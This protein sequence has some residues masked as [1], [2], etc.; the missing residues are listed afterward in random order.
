MRIL[1]RLGDE[2]GQA[3]PLVVAAAVVLIGFAGLAID[4]GRVWVAKQQL[5]QAVDASAVAAGQYL[6]SSQ[7]AYTN[8]ITYAAYGSGSKNPATGV[9]VTAAQPVV[10]FK[11][12]PN[13]TGYVAGTCPTDTSGKNCN[14]TGSATPTSSTCNAVNVTETETV[15]AGFLSL[16]IPHFTIKASS[17]AGNR[18]SSAVPDPMNVEVILDTTESM[19][20]DCAATLT[21][22]DGSTVTTTFTFKGKTTNGSKTITSITSLSGTLS[23][24]ESITASGIPSGTVVV[25]ATSSS[26]T[27]SQAATQ[28]TGSGQT[29]TF[30]VTAP[31][32][33]DKLDCAK[34][35]VRSLLQAMPYTG[36]MADDDVGIVVFPALSSTL[37]SGSTHVL[38]SPTS[39]SFET[40]CNS[41]DKPAVTYPPWSLSGSGTG[42]GGIPGTDLYSYGTNSHYTSPGYVDNYQGYQAIP[43]SG[44]Y[45]TGAAPGGVLNTSSSLVNSVYWSQCT[46][47]TYASG[48]VYGIKDKGGQG[49]YLAG[50]ITAAQYQLHAP[51]VRTTGPNGQ[52]VTNAIII[53]SDGELGAPTSSQDGVAPGA[54]G[55]IGFTSSTPCEDAINAAAAAKA[56]STLIFSIAYDSGGETCD[57]NH[58]GGYTG[59]AVSLMQALA[60]PSNASETYSYTEASAGELGTAF[61]TALQ[62]LVPGDS[63]LIPDCTQAPPAC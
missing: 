36:S 16:F 53:L 5:Q 25:S 1:R 58:S 39:T 23:A 52:A 31:V 60:T 49:S 44:D 22:I 46:G 29:T 15:S 54:S 20:A 12:V 6:P 38:Q 10:T 41:A 42:V 51:G 18:D 37:S 26:A 24:G 9:G 50:A 19:Q 43:L 7:T 57:D 48:D 59:S 14:P 2:S 13:A 56:A 61:K 28:S 30:T 17:T 62:T 47:G 40:D 55:N 21:N 32:V 35:G 11:C 4:L 8:A 27:I 33:P 63:R 45:Q 34:A 3:L